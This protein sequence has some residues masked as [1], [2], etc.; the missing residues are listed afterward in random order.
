M[1]TREI[2]PPRDSPVENGEPVAG[3]WNK[4]FVRVDLMDIR[5]PYRFPL[6]RWLKDLRIKEWE[7][8]GA[9]DER[10][11]LEAFLGNFKLY[12][13]VHVRLY[14]KENGERY[15][16]SKL[17]PGGSLKLPKSLGNAS[18]EYRSPGFF[19]RI[20]TWLNADT[21]KL[22][23]DIAATKKQPAF[24]AH[25]SYNMGSR[26]I[27][28]AV[29]SL[30]FCFQRNY[31][32]NM[33]AYKALTAVR[34]DIVLGERHFSLN[35]AQ[36][37]GLFRDCKGYFPY[38]MRTVYCSSMGFDEEGRRYGFHI[39]ENQAVETRK[40]NENALWVDKRFTP[41]PPV[42]ITMPDGPESNWIIQDLDGMVD[43]VFTPQ[44]MKR[45][46]VRLFITGGDFIVPMGYYNGVLVSAKG[47]QIHVRNQWGTGEKL[48]L[49]V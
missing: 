41:L 28:P 42:R 32:R 22:D 48:Y 30:N 38:R 39:A 24:T 36:C 15:F 27:T 9:Q 1:Y 21:I 5:K 49:R 23:F 8:F 20:H 40:N 7:G 10:F 19:F 44:K 14:N 16:F 11:F 45:M 46:G 37:A 4:A 2:L 31:Q 34:G 47:E 13:L 17:I 18:V 33:Y 3:T 43:L 26:D 25:L 35:S 12:Q 6:P 29:V